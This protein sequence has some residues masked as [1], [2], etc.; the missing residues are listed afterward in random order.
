[1]RP[2]TRSGFLLILL[3]RIFLLALSFLLGICLRSRWS[4]PFPL[5]VPALILL[6]LAKVQ[7][8]PTLT[9]SPHDL[10]LWTDGSVPFPF[11]KGGSSVLA[12]CSLS[13]ALRPLFPFRQAQ[14]DQLFPQKPTLFCKLFAG[15]GSTNKSAISLLFSFYLTLVLS[16]PP[17][18]LVHL[19][20][21]LKLCGRSGRNCLLYPPVLSGYNG[22]PDTRFS[23]G[24]MRL[25][26][27]PDEER[28]LRPLQS[29]VVSL[30]PSLVSTLVFSRTG[31]VL[32]HP[33]F[34][35]HRF[36]QFPPRNLCSLVTLVFA[37]TDTACC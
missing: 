37:A 6:S 19:S 17:F 1:M 12:N 4:S 30:L 7:L 22:F 3:G 11:D 23:R 33:N 27:W 32:S 35:T 18:P 26:S 16:S 36:P 8:S 2:L 15:L 9:L 29:H 21:Y 28:Y 13:T 31:G 24:T 20:S 14:Y 34:S 25:T 5:H 10:V